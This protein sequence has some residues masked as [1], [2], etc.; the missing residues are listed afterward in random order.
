MHEHKKSIF[1][2]SQRPVTT[3]Q[4]G[5]NQLGG[6]FVNG[7]PLPDCVRRR[8]VELA[9]LG[10]RPCDISRQLLVSHGC[11]SKILTRF[12]E[13][14]SIRPGSIGGNKNKNQQQ[15]QSF[16]T[17][18]STN[19]IFKRILNNAFTS[20]GSMTGDLFNSSLCNFQLHHQYSASY[21]AQYEHIRSLSSEHEIGRSLYD[22]DATR[23]DD[24]I[25]IE[26][27][28][29][30]R[31]NDAVERFEEN[32]ESGGRKS[33]DP[34]EKSG[35]F[36]R[37]TEYCNPSV[38]D[39]DVDSFQRFHSNGDGKYGALN[40]PTEDGGQPLR[41]QTEDGGQAVRGRTSELK[42]YK[43]H[44]FNA[45]LRTDGLESGKSLN[46]NVET[47]DRLE[48][49]FARCGIRNEDGL[50]TIHGHRI[51][52]NFNDADGDIKYGNES[53]NDPDR[54]RSKV[55][56]VRK[57]CVIPSAP[58]LGKRRNG[59]DNGDTY[60]EFVQNKISRHSRLVDTGHMR[61]E[62]NV[63]ERETLA[64]TYNRRDTP[65]LPK[66]GPV[67][68]AL[69]ESTTEKPSFNRMIELKGAFDRVHDG[70]GHA[71]QLEGNKEVA[72]NTATG[73]ECQDMSFTDRKNAI[74]KPDEE[75]CLPQGSILGPH[76]DSKQ[77]LRSHE[78]KEFNFGG[79]NVGKLDD[80]KFDNSIA[81][82]AD[83]N[84][85]GGLATI[86][87]GK[88]GG[89][90][91]IDEILKQK[92]SGFYA[93]DDLYLKKLFFFYYP[94]CALLLNNNICTCQLFSGK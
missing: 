32:V 24:V 64:I 60:R 18:S 92:S 8:I 50:E 17:T 35:D 75:R 89:K 28:E 42:N 19:N 25:D 65:N 43:H 21:Q 22:R 94:P 82:F 11:V 67:V 45:E 12:Y 33:G 37:D 90:Y 40:S 13:T 80:F 61:C 9:L 53:K 20:G 10:V 44:R 15:S 70:K 49:G 46:E 41:G 51:E 84:N 68:P 36:E 30:Q 87:G 76:C 58:T 6:V 69:E 85:E 34:S 57:M 4:A 23:D 54:K 55:L 31:L 38:I 27:D 88:I 3:C 14:G 74:D 86:D 73:V 47:G 83:G 78:G 56:E 26:E 52:Q 5:V 72:Q 59:F 79:K 1:Q 91:C 71:F 39:K 93:E 2:N 63:D 7:R 48:S 66:G 29:D 77:I 62:G 81:A 16:T